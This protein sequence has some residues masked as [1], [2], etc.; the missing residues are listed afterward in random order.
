VSQLFLKLFKDQICLE[1]TIRDFER[2]AII[3]LLGVEILVVE[4]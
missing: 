4:S 3:K 1:I 2:R